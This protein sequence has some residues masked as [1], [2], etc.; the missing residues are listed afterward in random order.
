MISDSCSES[1]RH[2]TPLCKQGRR[3]CLAL[4]R[5]APLQATASCLYIDF[6]FSRTWVTRQ[7]GPRYFLNILQNYNNYNHPQ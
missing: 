3:A 4:T 7:L 6:A 1:G 5:K 2:S